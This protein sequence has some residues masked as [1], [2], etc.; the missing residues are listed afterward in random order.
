VGLA[1]LV[2]CHLVHAID[3]CRGELIDHVGHV[4]EIRY[5]PV[6]PLDGEGDPGQAARTE[7]RVDLRGLRAVQLPHR[8]GDAFGQLGVESLP[9]QEHE[10]GR[11]VAHWLRDVEDPHHLP[12]LQVD[13]IDHE[14]SEAGRVELEHEVSRQGLEHIAHRPAGVRLRPVVGEAE[15]SSGTVADRRDG[16]HALSICGGGEQADEAFDHGSTIE[17]TADRDRRHPSRTVDRRDSIGAGDRDLCVVGGQLRVDRLVT[18]DLPQRPLGDAPRHTVGT[19]L[20]RGSAEEH[21]LVVAQPREQWVAARERQQPITHRREVGDHPMHRVDGLCE[22]DGELFGPVRV[23][24]I[25]LD[26]RPRLHLRAVLLDAGRG[27][28]D[29]LVVG[30]TPHVQH[31]V[32]QEVDDDAVA[33]EDHAHRV[34]QEWSV[35][36]DDQGDRTVG[37]PAVPIAIG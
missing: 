30:P 28:V 20:V 32:D 24:A 34:D 26:L 29:Q 10:D 8:R 21:E 37:V 15:H 17:V 4:I 1:E 5:L 19:D 33:V 36:G 18:T 3:P 14:L 23:E 31:R 35:I 16:E 11:P 22:L 6:G 25:D 7:E 2:D 13:H 9:R 12:L 27:D